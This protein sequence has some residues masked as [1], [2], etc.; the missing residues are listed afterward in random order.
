MIYL[1]VEDGALRLRRTHT[2]DVTQP[3]K[4]PLQAMSGDELLQVVDTLL[5]Q[6]NLRGAFLTVVLSS[7]M[8]YVHSFEVAPRRPTRAMLLYAFEEFVPLD[9]ELLT[10]DFL[11]AGKQYLGIA[12]ETV[13]WR[14]FLDR[15]HQRGICVD[16]ITLDALAASGTTNS[17]LWVDQNHFAWVAAQGPKMRVWRF[18]ETT[19]LE[20]RIDWARSAIAVEGGGAD[21]E[22]AGPVLP[23]TLQ[24][25]AASLKGTV[26]SEHCSDSVSVLLNL[27]RGELKCLGQKERRERAWRRTAQLGLAASLLL[28]MGLI[29]RSMQIQQRIDEIS[30]WENRAWRAVFPGQALPGSVALRVASERKR[31]EALT[32]PRKKDKSRPDALRLLCDVVAAL[33]VDARI[34]LQ[35][36]RIENAD[37]IVRGRTTD[38]AQAERIAKAVD[39]LPALD[40]DPVRTD[41]SRDAGVQFFLHAKIP[42]VNHT[43]A[44]KEG[45]HE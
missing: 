13:R 4:N 31:L 2:E 26:K 10:C 20:Q 5:D 34:D 28:M 14:P 12:I 19:T 30:A 25:I 16:G 15:L 32:A 36:L 8:T 9:I 37:V 7:A 24:A 42:K 21:L 38:H 22:V 27:A 29:Y 3:L 23:A 11:S 33:P 18:S 43:P 17:I 6:V 41:R 39:A 1:H 40:C 45:S 44:A 35:E